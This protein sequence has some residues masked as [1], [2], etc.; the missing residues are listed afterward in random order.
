MRPMIGNVG[1]T[2]RR[3]ASSVS[4]SKAEPIKMS[5]DDGFPTRCAKAAAGS[6][7]R[8][9]AAATAKTANTISIR[10]T[11]SKWYH[12][13]G[14]FTLFVLRAPN[15]RNTSPRTKER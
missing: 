4:K 9:I 12:A 15:S 7:G 8:Y 6:K 13:F 1:P 3:A 11:P 10:G 14:G 2:L 5:D